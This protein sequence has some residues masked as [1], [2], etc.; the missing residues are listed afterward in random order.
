M[1]YMTW[2]DSLSVGVREID[3]QHKK[4]IKMINDFY[5]NISDNN[6]AVSRLLASLAEYTVYHFKTE[7]KYMDRFNYPGTDAHKNEHR[8]FVEKVT[9][10][11][12]R[13]DAGK[14][15]ISYEITNFVKDWVIKHV[16][17]SDK[18]YSKCFTD[19]G[20]R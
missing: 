16:M 13:F 3:D 5:E 4:L 10:V 15:V 2:N 12:T 19:N 1:A 7:E 9:D 14:M 11:K 20:L 18:K 6:R 17:G 8:L